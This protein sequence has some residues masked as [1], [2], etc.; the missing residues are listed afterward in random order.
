M[1]KL[2]LSNIAGN[3]TAGHRFESQITIYSNP[4]TLLVICVL[5]VLGLSDVS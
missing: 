1:A 3:S 2:S 5:A 4:E